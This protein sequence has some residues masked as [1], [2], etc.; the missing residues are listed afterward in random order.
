MLLFSLLK[1][2]SQYSTSRE[3]EEPVSRTTCRQLKRH[4]EIDPTADYIVGQEGI[5][6][7]LLDYKY[8]V[9]IRETYRKK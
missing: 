2:L 8:F 6:T 9:K 7:H 3:S 1:G 5:T 4:F